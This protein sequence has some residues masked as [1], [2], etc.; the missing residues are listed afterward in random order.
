[1]VQ[2]LNLGIEIVPAPIYRDSDG[3]A[4]SSRNAYLDSEDRA[5]A[6]VLFRALMAARE[7]I[8][9]GERRSVAVKETALRILAEQ[10]RVR[11]EYFEIV[12]LVE[13]QPVAEI[14][15]EVRI[16]GA[17]W[18]GKTRLIDNVAAVPR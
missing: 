2:D 6:P 15:S 12:D 8:E 3:L 16:A 10:P 17:I 1:M 4:L 11:P 9:Q 13:L 18:V 7:M 5:A 14:T